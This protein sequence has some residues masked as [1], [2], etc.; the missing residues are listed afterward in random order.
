MNLYEKLNL[1][2]PTSENGCTYF[3][4]QKINFEN[5]KKTV[6][7]CKYICVLYKNFMSKQRIPPF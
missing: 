7:H 6:E 2:A 5:L 3:I 1:C 4:F